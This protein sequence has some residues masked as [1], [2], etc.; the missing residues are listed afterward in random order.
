MIIKNNISYHNSESP[1]SPL[2]VKYKYKEGTKTL[3]LNQEYIPKCKNI[4]PKINT[5]SSILRQQHFNSYTNENMDF[6][7]L[8]FL[9][10]CDRNHFHNKYMNNLAPINRNENFDKLKEA[11]EK[12]KYID[13]IKKNFLLKSNKINNKMNKDEFFKDNLYTSEKIINNNF[14]KKI[15]NRYTNKSLPNNHNYND[16]CETPYKLS[17]KHFE[18]LN[19]IFNKV[20]KEKIKKNI[21]IDVPEYSGAYLS[22][23]NDYSIHENHCITPYNMINNNKNISK[24]S[25]LSKQS[26]LFCKD[27][28]NNDN[29]TLFFKVYDYHIN[30]DGFKKQNNI[31]SDY[32]NL[33][34]GGFFTRELEPNI[35]NGNKG[36][37]T[38]PKKISLNNNCLSFSS[39]K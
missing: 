12:I 20:E 21:S 1:E 11:G 31:F 29:P 37:Y 18:R 23:M 9:K 36:N 30:K 5:K 35:N 24:L 13:S 8:D 33:N 22:N 27:V 25:I 39:K 19:N 17:N 10:E 3:E 6:F 14:Y 34:K 26:H 16:N 15:N 2:N 38:P 32:A 28:I 4:L 7:R